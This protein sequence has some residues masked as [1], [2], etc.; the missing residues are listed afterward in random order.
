MNDFITF[1]T[2]LAKTPVGLTTSLT[3]KK[4]TKT[5]NLLQTLV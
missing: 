3:K 1:Y 5:D 2:M 4:F